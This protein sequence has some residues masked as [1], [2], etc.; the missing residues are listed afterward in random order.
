M[1]RSGDKKVSSK[2][3]KPAAKPV[4]QPKD[5]KR[6]VKRTNISDR[7][8]RRI[9]LSGCPAETYRPTRAGDKKGDLAEIRV[10]AQATESIRTAATRF[11]RAVSTTCAG[12]LADTKKK[13]VTQDMILS[14]L[15][16]SNG[17]TVLSNF[18]LG[19]SD[20]NPE[21]N[22]MHVSRKTHATRQTTALPRSGVLRIFKKDREFVI[23]DDAKA[24][25]VSATAAYIGR[26]GRGCGKVMQAAKRS[27][28]QNCDVIATLS[29]N[30]SC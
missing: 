30:Y 3:V 29:I 25:I 27:T 5:K 22:Q 14:I 21:P 10:S 7:R 24:A 15:E 12:K 4:S 13:T 9:V 16:G 26:L 1:P 17:R 11:I 2:P 20:L 23:T 19:I 18:N 8:I 28:I 6:R